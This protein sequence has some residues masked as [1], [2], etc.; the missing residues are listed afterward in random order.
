MELTNRLSAQ[1][2]REKRVQEAKR[3]E[4]LVEQVTC[5]AI[6]IYATLTL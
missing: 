2:R 3:K 4:E 6:P 1:E 5:P